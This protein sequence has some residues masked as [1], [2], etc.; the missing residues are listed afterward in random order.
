M[1]KPFEKKFSVEGK[2]CVYQMGLSIPWSF[3]IT[4]KDEPI[5]VIRPHYYHFV[6]IE[7]TCIMELACIM[8]TLSENSVGSTNGSEKMTIRID[9]IRDERGYG[10]AEATPLV[11]IGKN[12]VKV[13]EVYTL[14]N[15]FDLGCSLHG[16]RK[17]TGWEP[18]ECQPDK[19]RM[20]TNY[21]AGVECINT[22][23]CEIP[24]NNT[25]IENVRYYQPRT[26]R[27]ELYLYRNFFRR[28]NEGAV[29][30]RDIQYHEN[31][32]IQHEIIHKNDSKSSAEVIYAEDEKGNNYALGDGELTV[33]KL[34]GVKDSG[35][36]DIPEELAEALP[37][38]V[39]LKVPSDAKRMTPLPYLN[40]NYKSRVEKAFVVSITD[41][42]G[43][44]YTECRSCI[45]DN[46]FVYKV[47]ETVSP[48][49]YNQSAHLDCAP[50]IHVHK[51]REHC[52]QWLSTC[53]TPK[54][55]KKSK[56]ESPI[57]EKNENVTT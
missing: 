20:V 42:S 29:C 37:V 13:G 51:F 24:S 27:K 15:N 39:E 43:K 5:E 33:W 30:G 57:V 45:Y 40:S 50:G 49:S 54:S 31:G 23:L 3:R 18:C 22:M 1:S 6:I 9:K 12:I 21:S 19:L 2:T 53:F 8:A 56:A 7:L 4:D 34:C 36:C 47:G 44:K 52:D 28:E 35:E 26:N 17:R 48:D 10:C 46:K 38:Y 16:S 14:P 41:M 32:K 25:N 55:I 11:N